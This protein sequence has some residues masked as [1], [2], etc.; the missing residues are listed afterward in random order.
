MIVFIVRQQLKS[1]ERRRLNDDDYLKCDTES[2]QSKKKI[3]GRLF[4]T[5]NNK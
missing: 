4:Q 3:N 1:S 5:A 2:F